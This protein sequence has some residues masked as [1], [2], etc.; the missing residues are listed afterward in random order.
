MRLV[1]AAVS[2]NLAR[3]A[4]HTWPGIAGVVSGGGIVAIILSYGLQFPQGRLRIFRF[5]TF[6]DLRV[7][8]ALALWVMVQLIGAMVQAAQETAVGY[9]AHLGGAMV[10][11]IVWS[12]KRRG[13]TAGLR[14]VGGA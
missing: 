12:L 14:R 6:F 13:G 7:W 10:G 9:A 11:L 5:L 2:G 8:G 1:A 4:G 3:A